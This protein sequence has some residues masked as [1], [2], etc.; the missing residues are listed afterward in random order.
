VLGNPYVVKDL[1]RTEVCLCCYSNC[2][3]SIAA[4]FEVLFGQFPSKGKLP[5][6]LSQEYPYGFGL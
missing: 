5:V 1:P 3:D 2:A 4:A 6:T